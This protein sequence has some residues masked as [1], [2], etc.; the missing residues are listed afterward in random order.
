[1]VEEL[2][3]LN[4]D[5]DGEVIVVGGVARYLNG[6]SD[7]YGKDMVDVVTSQNGI[8]NLEKMGRLVKLEGPSNFPFPIIERY[9]FKQGDLRLDV[10]VRDLEDVEHKIIQGIKVSTP[11]HD[12]KFVNQM[13]TFYKNDFWKDKL[14]RLNELYDIQS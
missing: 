11:E 6:F 1:M 14:V 5:M 12:L 10:F 7:S 3:K 2:K 8:K 4:L 9:G 13:K